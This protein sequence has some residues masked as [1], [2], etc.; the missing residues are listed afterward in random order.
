MP[1]SFNPFGKVIKVMKHPV[2]K[3]AVFLVMAALLILS[4]V[5]YAVPDA[6]NKLSSSL[7][8]TFTMQTAEAAGVADATCD[9][10]ADNAQAQALVT[11]LPANGGRLYML[12]GTYVWANGTTVTRAIDNVTISG[13]GRG[14]Y[15][16]GDGVTAPFTAGGNNWV[17]EDLRVQVTTAVLL[18]A[19]GATTGWE[20]RNVTTSDGFYALRSP[21]GDIVTDSITNTGLTD[22][23]LVVS[24]TGGLQA[25][26]V[27]QGSLESLNADA[28]VVA[29]DAPAA[30]KAFATVLQAA[31]GKIYVCDSIDD[32]AEIQAAITAVSDGVGKAILTGGTFYFSV[33]TDPVLINARSNISLEGSGWGTLL[34]FKEQ[35]EKSIFIH[36][37]SSTN[38]NIKNLRI[39]GTTSDATL[40]AGISFV[41]CISPRVEGC[42]VSYCTSYGIAF[43]STAGNT[44]T[45][46]YCVGNTSNNNEYY[47]IG[48]TDADLTAT[49]AG[50]VIS[51][52]TCNDN[53]YDGIIIDYLGN[54]Q[55]TGNYCE[56]NLRYGL[57]ACSASNT[58]FV[59]NTSQN[60]GSAG[61]SGSSSSGIYLTSA[62]NSLVSSNAIRDSGYNGIVA[63][64]S[65]NS[66]ITNNVIID[67]FYYGIYYVNSD[68]STCSSNTIKAAKFGIIASLSDGVSFTGNAVSE[69]EQSDYSIN[70]SNNCSVVGNT[71]YRA[72]FHGIYI[73]NSNDCEVVGNNVYQYS[74]ITGNYAGIC[75]EGTTDHCLIQSNTV[76]RVSETNRGIWIR[77]TSTN[78][79]VKDNDLYNAGSTIIR[80]DTGLA[81]FVG[82]IG[83]IAP[84]EIR[85]AS[86][87]LVPTGTCTATTVSGTF[88]ESPLSLKPG[89]NTMTCTA[90]GV[91]NVVMPAGSTAVVTSGDSLV[92]DSPK[93]C[94]A[95]ATTPVTVATGAGADTFTITVHHNAFAWH[96]PELQDIFVMK[97]VINRT[98]AGGTATAE[99]NV[100]IADNGTV[101]D[102]G[103][104]FFEN[105]LANNA[106]AIHDSYVAGG[107]SYG[108]Q[109]IWVSCQDSASATGGWV[110]GKL[111]TEIADLLAGTWY[112]EYVGK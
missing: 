80:D 33:N 67:P 12:T 55:I 46:I 111:D 93:T 100:G 58:S 106:A 56:G 8:S 88:T 36:V 34:R 82:N 81:T 14:T 72:G 89:A 37:T 10:T 49:D 96:D 35:T 47:G 75:T 94:P 112:V 77:T 7:R 32:Q 74:Y 85:T 95:G 71:S 19:M 62:P 3:T 101:D 104:E 42:H 54:L 43:S 52:N 61:F 86:G 26:G 57:H 22:T 92:T 69:S 51:N 83:Y 30:T 20:W 65:P 31:G 108:T 28:I 25:D 15:L 4:L 102:P 97:V 38:I 60:N 109:T 44:I 2:S 91:I 87:A 76:R 17:L 63:N 48:C 70:T 41:D 23:K 84:G 105:L 29:S 5:Y 79:M 103:V 6:G 1:N 9:G 11:A 16:T 27:V 68:Y 18:T 24:S 110:V 99:I 73:G 64:A 13:T 107:T 66:S 45:D 53:A 90:T 40:C 50:G 78:I 98:A 39:D 59:G 21:A